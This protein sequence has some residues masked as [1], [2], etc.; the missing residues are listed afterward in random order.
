M[1]RDLLGRMS[2]QTR[3][4]IDKKTV[5]KLW[6]ARVLAYAEIAVQITDEWESIPMKVKWQPQKK[7]RNTTLKKKTVPGLGGNVQSPTTS[8]ESLSAEKGIF[9]KFQHDCAFMQDGAME[10]ETLM[11]AQKVDWLSKLSSIRKTVDTIFQTDNSSWTQ[12]GKVTLISGVKYSSV[13]PGPSNR[14]DGVI[15]GVYK[16]HYAHKN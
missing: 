5:W 8:I 6:K 12:K 3:S 7:K 16:S 2:R 11:A 14:N 4:R 1:M 15:A 9:R 13:A 10:R